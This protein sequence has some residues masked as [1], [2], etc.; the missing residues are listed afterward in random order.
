MVLVSVQTRIRHILS[1]SLIS[2]L[3]KLDLSVTGSCPDIIKGFH[4]H[5]F[6]GKAYLQPIER[7]YQY[8][9]DHRGAW[10]GSRGGPHPSDDQNC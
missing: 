10:G 6:D 9:E 7:N 1:Y 5:I 2:V 8:M 4:W 3:T